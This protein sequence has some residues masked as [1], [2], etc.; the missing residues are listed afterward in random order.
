MGL[1]PVPLK[2][3]GGWFKES[4]VPRIHFTM[5]FFIVSKFS[6]SLQYIDAATGNGPVDAVFQSI[7]RITGVNATLL[8]FEV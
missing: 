1:P 7:N 3:G 8:D 5:F 4:E 6:L 2:W